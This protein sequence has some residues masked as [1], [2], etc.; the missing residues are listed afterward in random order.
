MKYYPV[1]LYRLQLHA[2]FTFYE[3]AS[4]LHYL[5]DLGVDTLYCSPFFQ[6]RAKSMHGYDVTNPLKIN[7]ELGGDAGF[8]AFQTL[9]HSLGFGIIL[10]LV[11]NHMAASVENPWWF[12]ILEKGEL[13]IYASYFDIDWSPNV[14]TLSG[15]VLVPILD[16]PSREALVEGKIKLIENAKGYF[17][18]AAG[19]QLPINPDSYSRIMEKGVEYINSDKD[20]LQSLL[21]EQHFFLEFWQYAPQN[22][23]YRRF[24]DINDL[25]ALKMDSKDAFNHYHQKVLQLLSEEKVQGVR[26]DHPD[27]IYEPY[28]YFKS[29]QESTGNSLY[30]VIEKI[31][32]REESLPKKWQVD[33]TVGYEYLNLINQLFVDKDEEIFFTD[34][35]HEF[36]E[37]NQDRERILQEEKRRFALL[38]MT[39]EMQ[40]M[41][42]KLFRN[43]KKKEFTQ[44]QLEE[45]IIE[46]YVFFPV[47]RTY[48]EKESSLMTSEEK[49]VFFE[50]FDRAFIS[51]PH[52]E[53][54]FHFL[55]EV[56]FHTRRLDRCEKD[57][58]MRFQQLGPS[59]MAKGFEDTHLYNYNRF[60]SLNEVGGFPYNF[61]ETVDVFHEKIASKQKTFPYGWITSS[62]HDTKRSFEMRMRLNVLSEI[63]S[64]WKDAALL[65][66]EKN[67]CYK[68]EGFPDNN[69]EYFLYQTLVGF[70]PAKRVSSE[71]RDQLVARVKQYI[72]KASRE[73]KAYTNWMHQHTS[74]ENALLAFIDS[75]LS[76]GSFFY[77]SLLTF[78][79]K[80]DRAAQFSSLSC[81]NLS[82]GLP[83]PLDVY[84]GTELWDFS[85]VDP[86]N[87]RIVDYEVRKKLLE[88][89][90][91]IV[92][93][94]ERKQ[95]I[96]SIL[97]K[98][99]REL[100]KLY[101][102]KVGLNLRRECREGFLEGE[103]IPL[104]CEGE[105]SDH[106]IA[107]LRKTTTFCTLVISS[108]F[109]Y[110][111]NSSEFWKCTT[112]QLPKEWKKASFLEVY[113]NET[114]EIDQSL[115]LKDVLKVLPFAMFISQV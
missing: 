26:V 106:V 57:F 53:Q 44:E 94:K 91:K 80:I 41:S 37:E 33:G 8:I 11:A 40:N 7:E 30:I 13:S 83:A 18:E 43:K 110:H 111:Y 84:Q 115:L 90:N 67:K 6:A 12:D 48:L 39:S 22:I 73:S 99:N 85:L 109:L 15:K 70:W 62:T 21:S 42:L 63:F 9:A 19:L 98:E 77:T 31:L 56:F 52:L 74:Y 78:I 20:V 93:S 76:E 92:L 51:K 112:I 34:L 64:E 101:L 61:G 113:T 100:L 5:K 4:L 32:E 59:I 65:W 25:A 68:H 75:I 16:V 50:A 95:W 55:K 107:Y 103:Y 45:A 46:L 114:F 35:Y 87:R 54:S 104:K 72:I 108:R 96:A 29:L 1:N 71:E 81:L 88:E 86:D 82:L 69:R 23:N 17:I 79:K 14:K 47:Y 38:H 27:G 89:I 28:Y 49:E 2:G 60:L 105:K 58:V 102:F 36:I 97:E 24:F 66:K 10:D 3:A